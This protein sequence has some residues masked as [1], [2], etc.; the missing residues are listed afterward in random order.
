M[1]EELAKPSDR[2]EVHEPTAQL[3][4][5]ALLPPG[6]KDASLPPPCTERAR[7]SIGQGEERHS[8]EL[9]PLVLA[10]AKGGLPLRHR[11]GSEA[12]GDTSLMI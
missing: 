11:L 3:W 9:L 8:V 1:L 7:L 10:A 5:E 12:R 2:L 4:H 6:R